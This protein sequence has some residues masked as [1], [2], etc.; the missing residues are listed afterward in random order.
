V[1][2]DLRRGQKDIL[3]A[4]PVAK[5]HGDA[6]QLLV[7]EHRHRR[8]VKEMAGR[9]VEKF[10]E[11]IIHFLPLEHGP[12]HEAETFFSCPSNSP[13]GRAAAPGRAAA[14]TAHRTQRSLRHPLLSDKSDRDPF[15]LPFS[16]LLPARS[17]PF[18]FTMAVI[19]KNS[20]KVR[21]YST[22]VVNIYQMNLKT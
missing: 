20:K 8:P 22:R 4:G 7:T 11:P 18:Y 21:S 14:A 2:G 15:H 5:R 3:A 17:R 10:T 9:Q 13:A 16:P 6:A 19:R 1:G 12:L